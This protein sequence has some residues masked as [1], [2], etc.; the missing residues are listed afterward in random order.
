M[1]RCFYGNQMRIRNSYLRE[2]NLYTQQQ[3]QLYRIYTVITLCIPINSDNANIKRVLHVKVLSAFQC[4]PDKTSPLKQPFQMYQIKADYRSSL[5]IGL[6]WREYLMP[7][8][9][10]PGAVREWMVL[11]L[12]QEKQLSLGWIIWCKML[13]S[14]YGNISQLIPYQSFNTD[15]G[16]QSL[17]HSSPSPMSITYDGSMW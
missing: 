14:T 10:T 4:P 12:A 16:C 5:Q 15:A 6:S 2:V 8:Y 7:N 9:G 11:E 17:K 3:C 13:Q 1:A